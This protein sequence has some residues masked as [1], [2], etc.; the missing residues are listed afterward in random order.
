[1]NMDISTGG[2]GKD[3]NYVANDV[4]LAHK[5]AVE[6]TIDGHMMSLPFMLVA[7]PSS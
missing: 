1:M 3:D 7:L 6:S 4:N 5:L 2:I